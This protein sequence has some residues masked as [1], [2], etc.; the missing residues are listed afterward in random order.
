M[1]GLKLNHVSK[2]SPWYPS[3]LVRWLDPQ[4]LSKSLCHRSSFWRRFDTYVIF[5]WQCFREITL[6]PLVIIHVEYIDMLHDDVNKWKHFPRYWPFARGIHRSPVNSPHKGQWRGAL[7]FFFYLRLNKRLSKQSWG[8]WFEMLS[9]PLWR[10]CNGILDILD[11]S[12][13]QLTQYGAPML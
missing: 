4:S 10:H 1:Q 5:D 9:H 6:Y 13:S 8:W 12:L 11:I 3:N 7:M 2:S